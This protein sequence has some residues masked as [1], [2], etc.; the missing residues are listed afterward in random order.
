MIRPRVSIARMLAVIGVIGLDC[1]LV[2]LFL[3]SEAGLGGM[4]VLGLAMSIGLI[5]TILTPGRCQRFSAGFVVGSLAAIGFMGLVFRFPRAWEFYSSRYLDAVFRQMPDS[6]TSP[7]PMSPDSLTG[8]V[9]LKL[10]AGYLLLGDVLISLPVLTVALL[11]GLLALAIRRRAR[12]DPVAS[13]T[14]P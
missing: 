13:P 11:G 8:D 9:E 4:F 2:R 6:L 5:G 3:S 12:P 14:L 10:D 7:V 1:G